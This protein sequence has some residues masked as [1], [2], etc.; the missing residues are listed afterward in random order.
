MADRA[1]R[2]AGLALPVR[3]Y[4]Q[5]AAMWVRAALAY[6]ASFAMF[7]V[8]SFA[9]TG[10]DFVGI[11]IIFSR[12]DNLGG[13]GVREVALLY[14]LTGLGIGFA[15]LTIGNV[16]R[17]GTLVRTGELDV[18]L[19]RPVPLLVQVC[20]DRFALRRVARITQAGLVLGWGA[21]SVSW[22]PV[23]ALV[24]VIA[25]AAA[26]VIFFCLF[27]LFSTFQFWWGDASEFA[28]AFTYGGNTITQYPLTVFPRELVV[29]LTLV[30]PIAF[31]NWYPALFLLDRADPFGMPGWLQLASPLAAAVL[32]A[33][34]M[35]FWRIGVRHY[36]STGS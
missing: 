14:G 30:V 31:V 36:T 20:A 11:W 12:I 26:A 34:T 28:N 22:T 9:L 17:L 10:L 1:A 25:V 21:T 18:M 3:Q 16:E 29:S 8:G 15:D 5:I 33:V 19:T 32:L 2:A 4:A 7:V 6:P 35:S 13:F 23:R 24:A 27:V